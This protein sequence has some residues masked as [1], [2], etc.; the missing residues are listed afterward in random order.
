M[1]GTPGPVDVPREIA[2]GAVQSIRRQGVDTAVSFAMEVD[3]GFSQ[4]LKRVAGGIAAYPVLPVFM[5]CIQPPFVPFARARALGEAV[6]SYAKTL[7]K[8]K[9]LF[10]GTGGLSHNPYIVFPPITD[11]EMGQE[12]K[13]YIL[14]GKKQTKVPQQDWIDW[15]FEA[16]KEAAQMFAGFEGPPEEVGV[17]EKWDRALLK[18]YCAGDLAQFDAWEAEQIMADAGIGA[19][20]VQSW[21]AAAQAMKSASG[22]D[23]KTTF[24]R[25][26][27]ELGIA[28]AGPV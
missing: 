16:H 28:E 21:I 7:N 15:E 18:D 10:I 20:E 9:I 24:Q 5:C 1:G 3:H 19:V 23:P 6:G 25:G 12:W 22:A 27:R 2:L 11:A 8:D 17:I 13:P 4:V 14:H 26:M